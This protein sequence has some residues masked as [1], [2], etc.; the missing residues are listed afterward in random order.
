[1]GGV[2]NSVIDGGEAVYPGTVVYINAGGYQVNYTAITAER[3]NIRGRLLSAG[4]IFGTYFENEDLSDHATA[5]DGSLS[6]IDPLERFD[7]EINFDWGLGRPIGAVTNATANILDSGILL[8]GDTSTPYD[9]VTLDPNTASDIDEAYVGRRLLINGEEREITTSSGLVVDGTADAASTTA[10]VKLAS[11]SSTDHYYVGWTITIFDS[12]GTFESRLITGYD[13]G[14]KTATLSATLGAEPDNKKYK[15][16]GAR[17]VKVSASFNLPIAVGSKYVVADTTHAKDIGP[18]YFSARWE[19][20]VK[21]EYS[22][23][24][25]FSVYCDD[26]ARLYVNDLLILDHWYSRISEVDGTIALVGGSLFPIKLEY[27]QVTGNASVQLRWR[28]RTQPKGIIPST[29]Y[30]SWTTTHSLSNSNG[31]VFVEPAKACASTSSAFGTGLSLATA[32]VPAKFT[33]QSRDEYANNRKTADAG[34]RPGEPGTAKVVHYGTVTSFVSGTVV[35]L[36]DSSADAYPPGASQVENAYKGMRLYLDNHDHHDEYRTI[37]H[38][39]TNRRATLDSAFTYIPSGT[40]TYK[41]VDILSS[42]ENELAAFSLGFP[43]WHT[44]VTPL[45]GEDD[46]PL[47]SSAVRLGSGQFPG[48]LTATYYDG[49]ATSAGGDLTLQADTLSQ[50]RWATE[51]SSGRP[52]DYTIDFSES[53]AFKRKVYGADCG[54]EWAGKVNEGV[55]GTATDKYHVVFDA[56]TA[57]A[58][59][60]A[61][62]DHYVVFRDGSCSGRWAKITEHLAAVG[63]TYKAKLDVGAAIWSDGSAACKHGTGDRYEV[64]QGATIGGKGPISKPLFP[65]S[66]TGGNE[67]T[68]GWRV[69]EPSE[70]AT[71]EM[72]DSVYAVRWSGMISASAAGVYTFFADLPTAGSGGA[73]D[74]RVKLWIDNSVVIMHWTSLA[75]INGGRT[76]TFSFDSHPSMHSISVTYKNPVASSSGLKLRWQSQAAGHK[77]AFSSAF[78]GIVPAEDTSLCAYSTTKCWFGNALRGDGSASSQVDDLYNHQFIKFS[79]NVGITSVT[80]TT[81]GSGSSAG[82]ATITCD[83]PCT[84]SGFQ[85][86]CVMDTTTTDA[87]ASLTITNAGSGYDPAFPPTI[88]CPGGS[89]D[90]VLTPVLSGACN[91]R[92]TRIGADGG[93]GDPYDKSNSCATFHHATWI[94]QATGCI[95]AQAD[96]FK[97]VEWLS[98]PGTVASPHTNCV[99][100]GHSVVGALTAQLGSG[101]GDTTVSIAVASVSAMNIAANKNTHIRINDEIMKITA[102][103]GGTLTVVRAQAQ[104]QRALHAISTNVYALSQVALEN[105]G[106]PLPGTSFASHTILFTTGQCAGRWANIT[107][108][109]SAS[110]GCVSLGGTNAGGGHN[111]L[112]GKGACTVAAGDK[113]LIK[114]GIDAAGAT[115]TSGAAGALTSK[116]WLS[117][118]GSVEAHTDACP[119]GART[120]HLAP[121]APKRDGE[122]ENHYIRFTSGTCG[123]GHGGHGHWARI[124]A[125]DGA[126]Q[127]A[128]LEWESLGKGSATGQVKSVK[129]GLVKSGGVISVI[130]TNGGS[131]YTNGDNAATVTDG[132]AGSNF[133]AICTVSGGVIQSVT[134]TNPGSDYTLAAMPSLTCPGGNNGAFTVNIGDTKISTVIT[135]EAN[136]ISNLAIAAGTYIQV[137]SEIMLVTLEVSAT[138]LQVER[139][140]EGTAA[141]LHNAGS[142]ITVVGLRCSHGDSYTIGLSAGGP[143][144]PSSRLFPLA[145]RYEA[146]FTPTLKGDY[147]VHSSLAQG[148]GLDATFYDDQELTEVTLSRVDP[149]VNFTVVQDEVGYQGDMPRSL[150]SKLSDRLSFSV[151]WAGLLQLDDAIADGVDNVFTFETGIAETDERV[152]LWIDNSLIIDR[153]ETYDH[154]S[155]TTFS[156]TIGLQ[157]PNYYDLKMEYKQYAGSHA[158]AVLKWHCGITGSACQYKS[159]VPS[160][161]L[162]QTREVAGSPFPPFEVMPAPTCATKSTLEGPGLSAATA[163]SPAAFT[164]Q[165]IDEYQ[166]DRGVGNETFV[167]RGEQCDVS[168]LKGRGLR[169]TSLHV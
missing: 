4:G 103:S 138:Q 148:S 151:R 113:Y 165:A 111:W 101:A 107:T 69:Y 29:A 38:Y 128:S 85:A 77:Q 42:N 90:A 61:Y 98:L 24:Y 49:Y 37:M 145:G 71:A 81:A 100:E 2:Q 154:L 123:A 139:G 146:V 3:Y 53:A 7:P 12:D 54:V 156:A 56:I 163:G 150:E 153:W 43:E 126:A 52:C 160:S 16:S 118:V 129:E 41:V 30:Y 83:Y 67:L 92:W 27:K 63:T 57:S 169:R 114:F 168:E 84:G 45:V 137:D 74:D 161:N 149:N 75:G 121:L 162:F 99:N 36:D 140:Q 108:Y 158:S 125:Y 159:I 50:P 120:V 18:D 155:A 5:P 62:L 95:C 34:V 78:S 104:T 132:S 147:Q 106:V 73:A 65:R 59:P 115:N 89:T 13:G 26:G 9:Q 39:E 97:L 86:T 96:N 142:P 32:G 21:A 79:S 31:S 124:S 14:T 6:S 127:C 105:V 91:G 141:V 135:L 68:R 122:F 35:E 17:V 11:G 131:G 51:C 119:L 116:E 20:M 40:T 80:V 19:G 110:N 23:V 64:Y 88:T 166:N 133:A 76:G 109:D 44:R 25:T 136:V 10:A 48:G 82:A 22:E 164:I 87:I 167:V 55:A 94:D 33:I 58:S 144:L 134:V 15:V 130:V 60:H 70:D 28:S 93:S 112:D 102:V 46:S 157:R 47:H 143:V 1:M 117:T 152:K 8:S 72:G 66:C